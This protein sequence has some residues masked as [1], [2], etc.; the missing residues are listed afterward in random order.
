MSNKIGGRS[1]AH[2]KS[3]AGQPDEFGRPPGLPSTTESVIAG[4]IT[5]YRTRL[6]DLER[7]LIGNAKPR[8]TYVVG[9]SLS[10]GHHRET[11]PGSSHGAYEFGQNAIYII[12]SDEP[13]SIQISGARDLAI[14]EVPHVWLA[15]IASDIL[16]TRFTALSPTTGR[17]DDV[18]G[19]LVRCIF[20]ENQ[21]LQ[22]IE[23][24]FAE[25]IGIAFGLRLLEKYCQYEL[26]SRVGSI[27]LAKWQEDL[28]KDLLLRN[29]TKGTSIANI[30]TACQISTSYFIRAFKSTTG[31]SPYQWQLR[32]RISVA[33]RLLQN[34]H[35]S[36]TAI[37]E[38]CGFSNVSQFSRYFT[39]IAGTTASQWRRAYPLNGMHNNED[40]WFRE[41]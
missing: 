41:H 2:E 25:Q 21:S 34:K 36:I 1:D 39:K 18:L 10:S 5:F 38:A 11:L 30:A 24:Y 26:K 33:K 40:E 22:N 19:H 14:A 8:K 28:A 13:Y 16:G 15:R 32:E 4:G 35:M 29:A 31:Y 23:P 9:V 12:D 27:R 37:A 17:V 20:S 6:T 3:A 7:N